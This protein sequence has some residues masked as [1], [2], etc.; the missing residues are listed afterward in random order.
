MNSVG[1]GSTPQ[2]GG[3]DRVV[4]PGPNGASR[5][6]SRREFEAL[7]LRERVGYLIEG[8]AQF[9]VGAAPVPASDA[10]KG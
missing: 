7:P 2:K 6:L 1:N 4:I 5:E 9:F 3:Y 8:T 10:M